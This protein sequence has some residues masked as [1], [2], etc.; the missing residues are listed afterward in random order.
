MEIIKTDN[1]GTCENNIS[2]KTHKWTGEICEVFNL[3][4]EMYLQSTM[5]YGCD[6]YIKDV[7]KVQT[8]PEQ[9]KIDGRDYVLWDRQHS[10]S[11]AELSAE[12]ISGRVPRSDPR[13]VMATLEDNYPM[14][15][16]Y[17]R[18]EMSNGS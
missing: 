2:M 4:L 5:K 3:P 6:S 7:K 17:V 11:N 18:K 12:I 10:K 9:T 8:L 16:V 15:G 1:C 13:V 14:W